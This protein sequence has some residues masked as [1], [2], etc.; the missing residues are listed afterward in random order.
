MAGL[1]GLRRRYRRKVPVFRRAS[2]AQAE[3]GPVTRI[4]DR[5]ANRIVRRAD[6]GALIAGAPGGE[7][8]ESSRRVAKPQLAQRRKRA[9]VGGQDRTGAAAILV[10]PGD[11]GL[12][13]CEL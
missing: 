3:A 12:D 13:A 7:K 9:R 10:H 4:A 6:M 5:T 8:T 11:Q 1:V 2:R